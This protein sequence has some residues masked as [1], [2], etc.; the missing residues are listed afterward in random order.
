VT[1][2]GTVAKFTVISQ[3]EIKTTVPEGATTGFVQV[4]TPSG[5]LTSNVV[6]TVKP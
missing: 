6:Y 4:E 3:F 2:N 1:F 5:A